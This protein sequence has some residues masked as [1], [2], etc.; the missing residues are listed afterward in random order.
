MS[1]GNDSATVAQAPRLHTGSSKDG[2]SAAIP[3]KR[4]FSMG[5]GLDG[6][7][8][9]YALGHPAAAAGMDGRVILEALANGPDEE[10]IA[11]ETRTLRVRN[12]G[13]GAVLQISETG[14]K[15]YIDKGWREP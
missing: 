6:L 11:A 12:G 2:L 15:R 10:Q 5:I 9:Y 8:P 3:I 7:N 14:G 4:S 1:Q 13:Y